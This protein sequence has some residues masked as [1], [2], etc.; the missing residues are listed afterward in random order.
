MRLA[1]ACV[2]LAA[3]G[4]CG[5]DEGGATE[6]V[7]TVDTTFGVP[8]TINRLVFEVSS[9]GAE[10]QVAEVDVTAEDLPGSLT[11]LPP[12]DGGD[13]TVRVTAFNRT[14]P[15]AVA[16]H[17]AAFADG[18]S[19]RI[20][21][22]LDEDCPPSAPCAALSGGAFEELPEPAA[23]R[24]CGEEA[25]A[26]RDTL[27]PI[28][29]ACDVVADV[30]GV[31]LAAGADGEE[32][33]SPLDPEMPFPFAFYGEPVDA[34]WIGDNGYVGMGAEPPGALTADIGDPR[35]LGASGFD[36][37][38]VLPFWDRLKTGEAGVCLAVTGEAPRR[39]LWVTW[40]EACFLEGSGQDCGAVEFG[41]LT[42]SVGFEETTNAIYAGYLD[43]QG[44]GA[45]QDRA[46]GSTAVIG[47][48]SGG[49]RGCTADECDAEGRCDDGTPCGYTEVSSLR[50]QD[51]LPALELVPQ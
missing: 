31:V 33:A 40:R 6:I 39:V 3:M 23:R 13:A 15:L 32:I 10:P 4:A 36:A 42:F 50:R 20:D 8:C 29:D 38:G 18:A 43:M 12:D 28:H 17:T 47:I 27:A 51:A 25:Y 22:L 11:V 24:G 48:T 14:V 45:N 37:P 30:E 49:E 41:R 7:V 19:Q 16:E 1:V 21:F 26:V 35:S 34:L 9:D 44:T 5:G 2:G 46:L